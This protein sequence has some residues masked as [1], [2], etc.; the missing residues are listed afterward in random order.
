MY[1][2]R[3]SNNSVFTYTYSRVYTKLYMYT[4]ILQCIPQLFA[5]VEYSTVMYKVWYTTLIHGCTQHLLRN[6][7]KVDSIIDFMAW[8][9]GQVGII[10]ISCGRHR[11]TMCPCS[12]HSSDY[13]MVMKTC[14]GQVALEL[15]RGGLTANQGLWKTAKASQDMTI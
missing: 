2:D 1:S 7:Y 9:L 5:S 12:N 6:V 14:I 11:W 3:N 15:A 13:R 8:W 10:A 4:Q